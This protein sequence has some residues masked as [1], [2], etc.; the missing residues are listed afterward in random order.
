MIISNHN[1]AYFLEK[2]KRKVDIS[3]IFPFFLQKTNK[4]IKAPKRPQA[5]KG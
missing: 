5:S 2:I 3:P 4:S 1:I